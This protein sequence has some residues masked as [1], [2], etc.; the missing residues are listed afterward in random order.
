M[1]ILSVFWQKKGLGSLGVEQIY[2]S[3]RPVSIVGKFFYMQKIEF[4]RFP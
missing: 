2:V 3:T 1:A 4:I